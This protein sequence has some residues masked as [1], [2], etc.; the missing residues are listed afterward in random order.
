MF[1]KYI[2]FEFYVDE[3]V[4]F[5]GLLWLNPG[6]RG[7]H[8]TGQLTWAAAWLLVTR[9]C[10]V[11]L[12]DEFSHCVLW[13]LMIE[14][15]VVLF[16]VSLDGEYGFTSMGSWCY[17]RGL[18]WNLRTKKCCIASGKWNV[19]RVSLQRFGISYLMF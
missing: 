4:N 12:L 1:R 17:S 10:P 9:I 11:Y 13:P 16:D 2:C 3:A 5:C 8:L 15:M 14:I 7:E 19:S 6:A 18:V